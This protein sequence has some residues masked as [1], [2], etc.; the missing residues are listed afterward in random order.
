VWFNP[1]VPDLPALTAE[2]T[3]ARTSSP[4]R[5][6]RSRWLAGA[7]VLVMG[8]GGLG[9]AL[10]L[11]AGR[12]GRSA[13]TA[14]EPP[15][16]VDETIA[17]GIDHTYDG[18]FEFF[19]GGGVAAFDCDDD[20][21]DELFLA[22]G[23]EPAA[24]YRNESPVGGALRF[25]QEASP[26]TD[27]TAVTG[28]YPLDFDGD[29]H[30]DLAVLR[31]GGNVV[32]RGLGD[33]RFED[34]TEHFG[35]DGGDGWTVA[36]SAT[37]EGANVLPTVAFGNYL[38]PDT[39]DRSRCAD[40]E[41]VRPAPTGDVYAPPVALSPGYCTLSILFSDWSR[42]GRRDLR[43]SNDRHY[44]REGEEQLWRIVPG[45]APRQYTAADGWRSLQV[46]GMGIASQD[47]TGDGYPEVFLTSQGDN[48]LQTLDG[49]PAQPTYKDIALARGVIAQR[50]FVGGDVLPSTAWHPEFEDVNN[51]GL[52][53]LFVSKGNVDAQ[54]GSATRDPSNLLIGQADGTFVEGAEAAGIVGFDRAR[55]A[56]LVDLNLD[57]MLDLVVVNRR[58]SATLWRNVG[59]GDAARPAPLGNW[60][61]VRLRQPAPNV[62]AIGAWVEVRVGERTTTREVTVGGGHAGG[63]LGWLHAGLGHADRADVRVRWPDVETGP[64]L[65]VGAAQVGSTERGAAQPSPSHHRT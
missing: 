12:A 24:L 35:I 21:R 6:S 56:A 5:R 52:L 39:P 30:V 28:A 46:W 61:A 43:V 7:A 2:D 11:P 33:C 59:N 48:K 31:R 38:A 36:F 51:D 37:W 64:C 14:A 23:T 47:L 16:Y 65:T 63:K 50:P 58:V 1:S 22:G 60:I 54:S 45:E 9:I 55:G 4:V 53:D 32:L 19:V 49:G 18:E 57:G 17:A 13:P 25:L 62:D 8:L 27:L 3:A 20:G 42:S 10:A 15:R 26:V 41:L 44:Y 34:A 29:G 40:S